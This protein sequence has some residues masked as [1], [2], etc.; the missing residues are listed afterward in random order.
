MKSGLGLQFFLKRAGLTTGPLPLRVNNSTLSVIKYFLFGYVP[1]GFDQRFQL[2]GREFHKRA[3]EPHKKQKRLTSDEE[4][5]LKPMIKNLHA[6]PV[7]KKYFVGS[8]KEHLID[9]KSING[10]PVQ[11]TL[12]VNHQALKVGCDPKTTSSRTRA[13]FINSCI[14]YAYLRQDWIYCQIAELDEFIFFGVQKYPPHAVWPVS[15][16][17]KQYKQDY[18]YFK[19]EALFLLHFYKHYGVPAYFDM[20]APKNK[21]HKKKK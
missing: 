4:K 6:N 13:E 7:F 16:H 19:Q 15:F 1:T 18:E 10:I 5:R 12:D 14:E 21:R 17:D 20:A 2:F 8:K 9:T 11:G 3:L